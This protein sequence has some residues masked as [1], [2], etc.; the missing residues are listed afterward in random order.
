MFRECTPHA[1]NMKYSTFVR[2]VGCSLQT[3]YGWK[4]MDYSPKI[5]NHLYKMKITI[6]WSISTTIPNVDRS[7][8]DQTFVVSDA[9]LNW[10]TWHRH[11]GHVRYTGLQKLVGRNLVDGFNIDKDS[12]KLDCVAY[13]KAKQHTE[14]FSE[15][16]MR[17]TESRKLMH[18]NL[19]IRKIQHQLN[20][21]NL[22]LIRLNQIYNKN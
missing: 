21:L 19:Y 5:T 12:P 10:K 13:T 9:L 18:I 4:R 3:I 14:P 20:Q 11:F 17:Y 1:W 16:T 15:S 2:V 7:C 22:D 8:D 6:W